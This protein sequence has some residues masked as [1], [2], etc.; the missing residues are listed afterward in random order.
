MTYNDQQPVENSGPRSRYGLPENAFVF[1]S[2]NNAYKIEPVI[3]SAWMDLLKTI[4]RSVLWIYAPTLAVE[5]NL[6]R[7]AAG[8]GVDTGRLIFAGP[9]PIAAHLARYRLADLF[10]DTLYCNGQT[11]TLDALW[12]GLPVLTC[13][14]ST[15]S[16]RISA[17]H[18]TLLELPELIVGSVKQYVEQARKLAD[19]AQQL[20]GIRNR[21]A[22][23]RTRSPLFRSGTMARELERAYLEM[24]R[25]YQAGQE[26]ASFSLE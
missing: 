3:F 12:A 24:W 5:A 8:H 11:T 18:L 9:M 23:A 2:F 20:S 13:A 16:S 14:G 22:A 10:L 19:D 4:P 15:F 6:V 25:R 17:S 26:P 7:E 21:L 1:C